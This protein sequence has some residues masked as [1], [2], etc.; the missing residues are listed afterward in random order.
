MNNLT[1]VTVTITSSGLIPCR[2]LK[3]TALFGPHR[4]SPTHHR[5]IASAWRRASLYRS[6]HNLSVRYAP[7]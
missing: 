4:S 5:F 6:T 3:T 7:I 1:D 2:K